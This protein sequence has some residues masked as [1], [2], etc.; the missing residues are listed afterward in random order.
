MSS[1]IFRLLCLICSNRLRLHT[2][3]SFNHTIVNFIVV[4][5]NQSKMHYGKRTN[6]QQKQE[7]CKENG[8]WP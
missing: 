3:A 4:C 1:L 8:G 7:D 2:V 5:V 6:E